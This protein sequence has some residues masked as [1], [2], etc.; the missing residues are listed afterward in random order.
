MKKEKGPVDSLRE[1]LSSKDEAL[2]LAYLQLNN[3]YSYSSE[4]MIDTQEEKRKEHTTYFFEDSPEQEKYDQILPLIKAIRTSGQNPTILYALII[5]GCSPVFLISCFRDDPYICSLIIRMCPQL[6]K[7]KLTKLDP[8]NI[9]EQVNSLCSDRI[10]QT[11]EFI[12][13]SYPSTPVIYDGMTYNFEEFAQMILK[14]ISVGTDGEE[15]TRFNEVIFA[16]PVFKCLL[17]S[18]GNDAYE[19][20]RYSIIKIL[21][22]YVKNKQRCLSHLFNYLYNIEADNTKEK[23]I[24]DLLILS[25][26]PLVIMSLLF[27]HYNNILDK[28]NLALHSFIFSMPIILLWPDIESAYRNYIGP[29]QRSLLWI[30]K[31]ES[32]DFG[33]SKTLVQSIQERHAKNI[34]NDCPVPL[35]FWQEVLS[36][37][38]RQEQPESKN[39]TQPIRRKGKTSLPTKL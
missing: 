35:L 8:D 13:F 30:N 1:I 4:T 11:A 21:T 2:I 32:F 7:S 38:S 31:C 26:I 3:I 19:H 15:N 20:H 29:R 5:A 39:Q 12:T 17:E 22:E 34:T 25:F 24:A 28:K 27:S 23:I 33:Q 9:L 10:Y 6:N 18:L 37:K 36:D 16:Y 14:N